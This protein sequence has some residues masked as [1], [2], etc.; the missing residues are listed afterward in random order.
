MLACSRRLN[1][2]WRC[3]R[4]GEKEAL[5]ICVGALG[6]LF[7]S[8][9]FNGSDSNLIWGKIRGVPRPGCGERVRRSVT[10][11]GKPPY[12]TPRS[13]VTCRRS[14]WFPHTHSHPARGEERGARGR[15]RDDGWL[16]RHHEP[17][18]AVRYGLPKEV[19]TLLWCVS[20]LGDV[21][22]RAEVTLVSSSRAGAIHSAKG[23]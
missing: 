2:G 4:V 23:W 7:D 18:L 17:G 11:C 10:L 20:S 16:C 22:T 9:P 13:R 6:I 15:P 19:G 3:W 8:E 1:S 12:P 5:G 14:R 21:G